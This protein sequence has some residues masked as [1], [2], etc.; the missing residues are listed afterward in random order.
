MFVTVVSVRQMRVV[1]FE[2]VVSMLMVVGLS[3][4]S[5]GIMLVE[6]MSIVHVQVLVL[7]RVVRMPV[8]VPL[9]QEKHD[10][11]SHEEHRQAV[12]PAQ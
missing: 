7:H 2:C 3:W 8:S 11:S 10:A 9:A 5:L 4:R 6:V 1:V 12:E